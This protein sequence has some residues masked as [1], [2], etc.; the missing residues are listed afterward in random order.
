MTLNGLKL[1]LVNI[2]SF[3]KAYLGKLLNDDEKAVIV[4]QTVTNRGHEMESYSLC[5]LLSA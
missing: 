4:A 5:R 1:S 2:N 3:H